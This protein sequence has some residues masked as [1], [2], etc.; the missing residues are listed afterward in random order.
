MGYIDYERFTRL[1]M[2][3]PSSSFND[4]AAGHNHGRLRH[5]HFHRFVSAEN[6]R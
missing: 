4:G 5:S 2:G 1:V 3:Q 6:H